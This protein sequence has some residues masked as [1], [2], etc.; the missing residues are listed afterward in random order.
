MPTFY[1][2]NEIYIDPV[3]FIDNCSS[4]DIDE[5]INELKMNGFLDSIPPSKKS[6][7]DILWSET[8]SKLEKNRLS[9]T[10][11]EEE[12]INTIVSRLA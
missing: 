2:D 6:V 11:T 9:L 12:I 4:E 3:E 8:I 10:T 7:N 5:L 1:T